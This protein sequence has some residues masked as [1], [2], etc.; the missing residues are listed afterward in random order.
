VVDFEIVTA[1]LVALDRHIA[2][3]RKHVP[4]T[5]DQLLSDQDKADLVSFN[6]MLALQTCI[7]L[8]THVISDQG[9]TPAGRSADAFVRLDAHGVLTPETANALSRAVGV[10]NLIA[11]A[12]GTVD[13][14]KLFQAAQGGLSDFERFAEELS[15][16]MTTR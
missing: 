2:Q 14:Q 6:L 16:W 12:Y 11:H 8:A 4:Q 3:V 5:W 7:D 9:W 10:R 13:F 1:K 15:R